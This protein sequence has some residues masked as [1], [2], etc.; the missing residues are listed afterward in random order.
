MET[1]NR[2]SVLSK[3]LHYGNEKAFRGFDQQAQPIV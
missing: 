1:A 3:G 2:D